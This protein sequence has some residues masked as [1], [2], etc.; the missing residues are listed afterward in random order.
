MGLLIAAGNN[1]A[2][3]NYPLAA[4]PATDMQ[5]MYPLSVWYWTRQPDAATTFQPFALNDASNNGFDSYYLGSGTFYRLEQFKN[6]ADG[7]ASYATAPQPNVWQGWGGVYASASSRTLVAPDGG[8]ASDATNVAGAV[9]LSNL[10][11]AVLGA[12]AHAT[13][14]FAAWN[15]EL[16]T[17]DF[18][19]LRRG[20]NPATIRPGRLLWYFPLRND[21]RD[22]GPLKLQVTGVGTWDKATAAF[23]NHPA[24]RMLHRRRLFGNFQARRRPIFAYG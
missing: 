4:F 6:P 11:L 21:L 10:R 1:T 20:A 9:V 15:A 12:T 5:S 3:T 24:V 23:T 13:A 2:K 17:D 7:L 19:S 18:A 22:Y 16:S 14:E 8:T